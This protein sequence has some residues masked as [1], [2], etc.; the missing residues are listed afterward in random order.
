MA[1]KHSSKKMGKWRRLHRLLGTLVSIQLLLWILTGLYFNLV[2]YEHLKGTSFFNKQVNQV[3]FAP[4]PD[5][6]TTSQVLALYPETEH[7]Q[8][9]SLNGVTYFLLDHKITRYKHQCQ[10]Q[11]LL[12][13]RSLKHTTITKQMAKKIALES[14]TGPGDVMQVTKIN[15]GESEWTKECNDLWRIDFSDNQKTRAYLHAQSGYVIGHK[16]QYTQ[17][18]DWMFKLHFMD[19]QN[20]GGFNNIFIWIF[21]ALALMLTLTGITNLYQNYRNK[22]YQQ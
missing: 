2:P 11:T 16:N 13:T 20:K 8:L 9:I 10:N 15:A 18:S 17:V 21:A 4:T 5:I 7:I 1:N 19:Y 6:A 12:N 3:S 14:Y 22:R